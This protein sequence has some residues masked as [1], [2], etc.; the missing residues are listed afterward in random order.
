LGNW[1]NWELGR[2]IVFDMFLDNVAE[3]YVVPV[4]ALEDGGMADDLA[5]A[6]V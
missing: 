3:L 6:L 4:F 5:G 2:D 1:G